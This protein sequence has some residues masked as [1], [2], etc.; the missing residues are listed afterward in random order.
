M[1]FNSFAFIFLFLPLSLLAFYLLRRFDRPVLAW[2]AVLLASLLFYA[3][4]EPVYVLVLIGSIVMNYG[5]GQLL[6]RSK[7]GSSRRWWLA[8]FGVA[9]NLGL[10]GLFKYLGFLAINLDRLFGWQVT[11]PA[12]A[13]PIGISFYTF[14]QIAYVVDCY[15]GLASSGG[16]FR[17]AFFVA[18]FPQLIAGPIVHHAELVPQLGREPR[19][20]I[21]LNFAI[22][23]TLFAAG[24]FKKVVIAD[25]LAT[26]S[27]LVFDE[28]AGQGI[29]PDLITAWCGLL[30]YTL[31]IYFDFS[32]YS[33][34]AVGL[35]RMFGLRL[36]INFASPY[37][38][39]SIIEFWR[40]WH[41]TLSRFLRDYL[42]LPLGGNRRGGARRYGNLLLTMLLGG[43]WHGAAW[44]FV[45]WGGL[46]GL[47]LVIN[48]LWRDAMRPRRS[49]GLGRFFGCVVTFFCV[50]LAWVPFRAPDLQAVAV[51]YRA[52]LHPGNLMV[53]EGWAQAATIL[54]LP[55]G[56][57]P[58]QTET[59]L[60]LVPCLLLVWC[61]PNVYEIARVA[62]PALASPAYPATFPGQW[63][64]W[65]RWRISMVWS[66]ATALLFATSLLKLNDPSEFL[67][68]QF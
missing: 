39:Q 57:F 42:Y 3:I 48:H 51:L 16:P 45:L 36:P 24:L 40:R 65:P 44:T 66:I 33:D 15:R 56:A 14:Q 53:P 35:A 60:L 17:Y 6:L 46:H 68:F 2:H 64:R 11:V 19:Q 50:S 21:G 67:Y 28:M 63:G 31:Q 18:F 10:L 32:G 49:S 37:K 7:R 52:L 55:T 38:A 41:I 9:A 13:L 25:T 8:A 54:G 1:L 62:S 5:I 22:G 26:P 27:H 20:R 34:M 43:L 58:L 30:A 12:L 61:A 47:M 23:L 59:M 29:S 4:G